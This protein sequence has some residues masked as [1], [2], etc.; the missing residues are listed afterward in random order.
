MAHGKRDAYLMSLSGERGVCR[1]WGDTIAECT[2]LMIEARS[3][4]ARVN[5]STKINCI[6][7]DVFYLSLFLYL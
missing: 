2:E 6:Q 3:S 7:A 5:R 4:G 1:V